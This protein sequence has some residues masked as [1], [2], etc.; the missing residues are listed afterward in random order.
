ML[1][2]LVKTT[3]IRSSSFVFVFRPKFIADESKGH[4]ENNGRAS[5]FWQSEGRN[6]KGT[7]VERSQQRKLDG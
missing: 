5:I 7:N 1:S 6:E 4:L 2:F 3:T